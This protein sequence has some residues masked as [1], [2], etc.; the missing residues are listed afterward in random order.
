MKVKRYVAQ[1]LF[2]FIFKI[3][4]IYVMQQKSPQKKFT[5]Q[6]EGEAAGGTQ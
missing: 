5:G 4:Y 1:V 2:P 3:A 6:N